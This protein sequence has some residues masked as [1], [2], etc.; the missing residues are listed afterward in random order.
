MFIARPYFIISYKD[1]NEESGY[2]KN[3]GKHLAKGTF[4]EKQSPLIILIIVLLLCTQPF[5]LL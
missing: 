2:E 4:S 1:G 5:N 3:E